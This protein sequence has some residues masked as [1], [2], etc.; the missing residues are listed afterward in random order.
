MANN[1]NSMG[2]IRSDSQRLFID[3]IEISGVQS[4][5]GQ[6][7][8]GGSEL[9]HLG[10]DAIPIVFNSAQIGSFNVNGFILNQDRFINYT[11]NSGFNGFIVKDKSNPFNAVFGFTSGYL[12]SYTNRGALGQIPQV[13][14][15]INVYGN[16]GRIISGDASG[17]YATISG[18][19]GNEALT[20]TTPTEIEVSMSDFTTN[21][22]TSYE[23]LINCS[24]VPFY[25]LGTRYPNNVEL[26]YPV[27]VT[28][29]FTFEVNDYLAETMRSGLCSPKYK[30]V[31]IR[32]KEY[33]NPSNVV[34]TYNFPQ[35]F[36][37][38]ETY[39]IDVNNNVIVNAQYK[40]YLK[41][42]AIPNNSSSSSSSINP[43]G[44]IIYG[45][46]DFN[47]FGIL[48]VSSGSF[49]NLAQ[50]NG[51]RN[52]SFAIDNTETSL[53]AYFL[54]GNYR[55]TKFQNGVSYN[56]GQINS[57]NYTINCM[58]FDNNGNLYGFG[59][60][61]TSGAAFYINKTNASLIL[62]GHQFNWGD[63]FVINEVAMSPGGILYA[64]FD[65]YVSGTH[66][67]GT[68]NITGKT[69]TTIAQTNSGVDGLSFKDS[70]LYAV[71]D[72]KI[73]IIN[74]GTA[75][76]TQ[77]KT[78]LY[79]AA[80]SNNYIE[81]LDMGYTQNYSQIYWNNIQLYTGSCSSGY[82]GQNS[83]GIASGGL[84]SSLSSQSDAD[85]QA[86]TY[87]TALALNNLNCVFLST[88]FSDTFNTEN[89]G[90][91]AA[92]YAGFINWDVPGTGY[93]VDLLTSGDLTP[94]G[95][96]LTGVSG[97]SCFVDLLGSFGA[98]SQSG[99][100]ILKT[101]IS[102][103]SGGQYRLKFDISSFHYIPYITGRMLDISIGSLFSESLA[104]GST[105]S[106]GFSTVTRTFTAG[107]TTT[108]KISFINA[109][110]TVAT[111]EFNRGVL[112]DNIYLDR[113]G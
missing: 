9:K 21:R 65:Q 72:D 27:E 53:T 83:T 39:S 68:Y 12:S 106:G 49:T 3:G 37:Q 36:F 11:G 62:T 58:E 4:V 48:D 108:A 107:S 105:F 101:G 81:G 87:A 112:I 40:K 89:G 8:N 33:N 110:S 74:T 56:I 19:T 55:L 24:R 67:L 103:Q 52:Y 22:V 102:F 20:I 99:Q 78:G 100:I 113:I 92:N 41:R 98:S 18:I 64:S 91:G 59:Y 50:I 26:D 63:S 30:D 25:P 38:G 96:P 79:I 80:R 1:I 75:N 45:I 15:S 109:N 10:M 34:A 44:Q 2:R 104:V 61:G 111:S 14:V 28:C 47:N 88:L 42:E 7:D 29:N 43:T 94:G 13:D 17:S 69:L 73:F 60:S 51:H 70:L 93:Y 84:F 76:F 95:R 16:V 82:V 46:A 23:I 86:L 85:S 71:K 90:V 31:I 54:D 35:M 5:R 6:Y 66:F 32:L 97:Y 77:I 57:S